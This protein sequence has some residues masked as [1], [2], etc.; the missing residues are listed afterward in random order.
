MIHASIKVIDNFFTNCAFFGVSEPAPF[1][2]GCHRTH[3][4]GATARF[5]RR[6]VACQGGP[7]RIALA[8]RKQRR[9][10]AA[11]SWPYK[12]KKGAR[13]RQEKG[14]WSPILPI[15]NDFYGS[16]VQSF[17]FSSPLQRKFR[18]TAL[19]KSPC[20]CLAILSEHGICIAAPAMV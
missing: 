12:R 11:R 1:G 15:V 19:M 7:A 10:Q 6:T 14:V 20:H 16:R 17:R 13:R 5:T 2:W 4:S 18:A 9:G 3:F 8:H